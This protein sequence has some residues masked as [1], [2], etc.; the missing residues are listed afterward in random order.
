MYPETGIR[1]SQRSCAVSSLTTEKDGNMHNCTKSILTLSGLLAAVLGVP[2]A[3][4]CDTSSLQGAYTF[5]VQG[6]NVGVFDSTGTLQPFAS[7]LLVDG[8]GY[9]TFDGNGGLT[10]VDYNVGN[11]TPSII[12][13]IP[14]TDDGFRTGQ[15]G[16]YSVDADCTG[17]LVFNVPG[18]RVVQVQL[19]LVA[20]GEGVFGVVKAEHA[21]SL[22]AAIL[23]SGT[24][25][26]SGCD[27][28]DNLLLELTHD[29]AKRR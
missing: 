3:K 24:A 15:T 22:P 7:P 21:P 14:L 11:G 9:F 18:G 28:G 17:S 12:P 26:D 5:K 13:A 4:A 20:Y 23:P 16:T 6:A 25:C 2:T 29:T 19:I 27:L 1:Q 8:A 10:K